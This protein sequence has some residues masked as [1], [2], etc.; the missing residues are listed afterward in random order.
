[1]SQ[2]ST[3]PPSQAGDSGRSGA[4]SAGVVGVVLVALLALGFAGYTALNPHTVTV[5]QQQLLTNTQSVYVVE[6]QSVTVVSTATSTTTAPPITPPGGYGYGGYQGCGYYGCYQS[7]GYSYF[8]PGYYVPG[9]YYGPYGY[10]YGY[11]GYPP[12]QSTAANN[13]TCSGYLYEASSGCTLLAIP[14]TNNP[15]P[16]YTTAGVYEY[17]TLQNLPSNAPSSGT[18]VTVS[19]QVHQGYNAAPNGSSCPTNFIV[20]SSIS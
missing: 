10:Y 16:S 6:T 15:Y 14:T 19:G 2:G 18:W 11:G 12:C 9:Y 20:V 8:S 7:P 4:R 13:V 3:S 17:Y 5:T 1:M